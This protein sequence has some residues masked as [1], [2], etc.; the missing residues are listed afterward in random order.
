VLAVATILVL[1]VLGLALTTL[2]SEDSDLAVNHVQSSQALYVAHAG[3]EYAVLR[4]ARDPRWGGLPAPGKAVGA[5]MFWIDPPSTT[6]ARGTTLP[7]GRLRLVATGVVA[8][9]KR[10]IEAVVAPGTISGI[11][12]VGS[13]AASAGSATSPQ[14]LA[15]AANGDLYVADAER[16]VVQRV[17]FL[18][19]DVTVVAGTGIAGS[20][21]DGGPAFK[22]RLRSPAGLCITGG[23]DLYIADAGAH[24]VRRVSAATGAITTVAGTGSAGGGGDGGPATGARLNAPHGIAADARGN[25]FIA[26]TGNHRVRCVMA[27]SGVISSVAG[28]GAPGYSGDGS[29]AVGARLNAPEDVA[30]APNGDL[31]IADTRNHAIRRVTA[32]TGIILTSAGAGTPGYSGDGGAATAARLTTPE[33]VDLGPDGDLYVA[34]TGNHAVR[35]VDLE[36]GTIATIAGTGSPG[37]SGDGGPSTLARL[38]APCGL[39]VGPSGEYFVADRSDGRVRRVAGVLAI[40]AWLETRV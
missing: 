29:R 20:T 32:G 40:V 30:V 9:A 19:G 18:T 23:G 2:V 35:R 6:D 26:D 39:A 5:G 1:L 14:G 10:V 3:I 31:Y 21:G 16:H 33:S 34:D 11:A 17:D 36:A 12:G 24:V 28:Q 22:A 15:V 13:E 27:S 8:S 37:R 38:D 4:L 25:L 7:P